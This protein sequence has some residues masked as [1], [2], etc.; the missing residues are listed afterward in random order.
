MKIRAEIVKPTLKGRSFHRLIDFCEYN[1]IYLACGYTD[2]GFGIDGLAQLVQ[3]V[4]DLDP[5]DEGTLFL[6]CGRKKDRIKGLLWEG[7]GFLM[8]CK[9]LGDD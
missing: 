9:R 1:K 5:F 2:L 4:F 8:L 7:D 6:F 3:C